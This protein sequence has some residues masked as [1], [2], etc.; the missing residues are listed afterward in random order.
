MYSQVNLKDY[1]Y[2]QIDLRLYFL[3]KF[4]LPV[5]LLTQAKDPE[6]KASLWREAKLTPQAVRGSLTNARQ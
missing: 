2:L 5:Y 6:G 3:I 4:F 1:N